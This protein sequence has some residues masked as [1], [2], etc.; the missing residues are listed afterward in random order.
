MVKFTD[1]AIEEIERIDKI[2]ETMNNQLKSIREMVWVAKKGIERS[3]FT[4]ELKAQENK[5]M[6]LEE[7]K[8][9]IQKLGVSSSERK[10]IIK[11]IN[12]GERKIIS[13]ERSLGIQDIICEVDKY[14]INYIRLT[15]NVRS[16]GKYGDIQICSITG[17]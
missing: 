10:A 12:S 3:A 15:A 14:K 2:L 17:V 13:S 6:K 11:K 9:E 7:R 16:M 5:I 1:K 4:R 8:D